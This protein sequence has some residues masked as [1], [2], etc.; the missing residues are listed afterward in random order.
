MPAKSKAKFR[1]KAPAAEK[2]TG[3]SRSFFASLAPATRQRLLFAL[4]IIVLV[5]AA[6]WVLSPAF[7]GTWYGDDRLYIT[8]NPLMHD[9]DRAWKAWFAPGSF[10]DYYPLQQIVQWYQWQLWGESSPF[11]YILCNL[12]LHVGSALLLWR[13]FARLGLRFAWLGGLLFAIYPLMVDSVANAAELKNTLSLPPFLLA[14]AA[15]ID[16]EQSRRPRDY[17]LALAF[18][19]VSMLCKIT[20]YFF[21]VVIVLYAWW[22][23]GKFT[24]RDCL[25][26]APFAAIA[27]P[28]S[29]LQMHAG[30]VYAAYTHYVSPGPLLL[31]GLG[32]RLE[33]AGLSLLFYFGH[34][35][36]PVHPMPLYPMW[37]LDPVTPLCFLPWIAIALAAGY[38]WHRRHDW[39]RP[40]LFALAFFTFGLAPFLGFNQVSYM[41]ILY[42]QD[43]TLYLPIIAIL[44][45][46]IAGVEGLSGHVPAR[47]RPAGIGLL[48]LIVVLV[49]IESHT[50]AKLFANQEKLWRYNLRYNPDSWM[51][52]HMLGNELMHQG[53]YPEAVD[54]FRISLASNP[55]FDSGQMMYGL[56]L[57]RTGDLPSAIAAFQHCLAIDPRYGAAH[58]MLGFALAKSGR[59][60]EAIE[61][62]HAFLRI[63]PTSAEAHFGLGEALA[64]KG[65]IPEAITQ[66]QLAV[67]FDPDNEQYKND[68]QALQSRQAAPAP[69]ENPPRQP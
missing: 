3:E 20:A 61:H 14:A 60:D 53:R 29:L 54:Q 66:L 2:S 28:L 32:E 19:L 52:H 30:A 41:C 38:C 34:S 6:F 47:W 7:K 24:L 62:F 10:I 37:Q 50:Y 57:M 68:L 33:L 18:Y 22:K 46:I 55:E 17:L 59:P 69:A 4:K 1:T 63:L 58:E 56:C 35:F 5:E 48:A 8:A 65:Q 40:A 21:P 25:L 15:W 23:R 36:L 9:P 26:A 42:V 43:H 64:L 51:I 27:I 39:G 67:Q 31:G 12:V 11:Y 13:L 45:L 44:G 16:F 49:G